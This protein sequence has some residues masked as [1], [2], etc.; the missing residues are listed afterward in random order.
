MR[1]LLPLAFGICM[2]FEC[3]HCNED[4]YTGFAMNLS[5]QRAVDRPTSCQSIQ[6][7]NG[8]LLGG[9]V[10]LGQALAF[11]NESQGDGTPHGHGLKAQSWNLNVSLVCGFDKGERS[12][13]KKRR[14]DGESFQIY[15]IY[16][17]I[18]LYTLI[19]LYILSYTF[20]YF[21]IPL[22]TLIYRKAP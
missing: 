18:P 17:H 2:C 10:G 8:K 1:V 20:K 13:G 7:S 9:Y 12:R 14:K 6:G 4:N 19:Y 11:A 16:L 22:Y 5:A 15:T 21:Q 3:P